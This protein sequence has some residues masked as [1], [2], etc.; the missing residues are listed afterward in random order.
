MSE[1]HGAEPSETSPSALIIHAPSLIVLPRTV[2]RRVVGLVA[3][4]DDAE[5]Y[6]R[7]IGLLALQLEDTVLEVG[8]GAGVGIHQAAEIAALGKV[9]GVDASEDLVEA[10]RSRNSD[11]IRDGYVEIQRG[12][13]SRLP[14]P[15]ATF[16]KVFAVNSARDWPR[17][18]ASL[19]EAR[20][21]MRPGGKLTIVIQTPWRTARDSI[22]DLAELWA[23]RLDEAGLHEV[24]FG[25]ISIGRG[26]AAA[27]TGTA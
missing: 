24:R 1:S 19:G 3:G 10:A 22:R 26:N 14:W 6:R 23:H 21:V 7:V 11:A 12:L 8:C 16:Q 13:S 4:R 15:D 9:C 2:A 17:P 25:I 20:R 18:V 5:L 27:I